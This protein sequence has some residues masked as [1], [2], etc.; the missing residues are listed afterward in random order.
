MINVNYN[1]IIAQAKTKGASQANFNNVESTRSN[2]A[3]NQDTLTLS[4]QALSLLEGNKNI[5]QEISP[6]Y[7]RPQ[8]AAELLAGNANTQTNLPVNTASLDENNIKDT[9]ESDSR[10]GD[11]M[12]AILDKRLGVDRKKLEELEAMMEEIGKNK[13][14]SPEEKAKALEEIGKMRDK[15]IEESIDIKKI[16]KNT[17]EGSDKKV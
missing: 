5:I 8:T 17:F 12:Q 9:T 7:V 11:M 1:E 10:F 3:E 6:I 13:N 14:L 2:I 16:A 15:I 4:N